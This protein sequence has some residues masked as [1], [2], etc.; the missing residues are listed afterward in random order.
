[1]T[2]KQLIEVLQKVQDQ[3]MRIMVSGYE[4]GYNDLVIGNGIDNNTPA[5]EY[6]ALDVNEE[7]YYGR[8]ERVKDILEEDLDKYHIIKTVIL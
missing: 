6:M 5:I 1:M 2:V 8:H 7:W 4:G 3:D